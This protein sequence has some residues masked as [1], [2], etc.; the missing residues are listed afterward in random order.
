M[1][2]KFLPEQRAVAVA[3]ELAGFLK[4]EAIDDKGQFTVAKG[5]T[6]V[7]PCNQIDGL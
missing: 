2:E 4:T 5:I 1:R 6:D 3:E 7:G